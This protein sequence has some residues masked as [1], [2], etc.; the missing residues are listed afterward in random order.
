MYDKQKG[1]VCTVSAEL[2][3]CGILMKEGLLKR[4]RLLTNQCP[5]PSSVSNHAI[6]Q[7]NSVP[8]LTYH[9]NT[10]VQCTH[11]TITKS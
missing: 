6:E 8:Y 1:V 5:L 9:I 10:R 11:K 7:K 3:T 4:R 2:G